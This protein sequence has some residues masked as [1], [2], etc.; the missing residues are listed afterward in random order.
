MKMEDIRLVQ[1]ETKNRIKQGKC[2]P[3]ILDNPEAEEI[4]QEMCTLF[5][6]LVVLTKQHSQK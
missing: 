5:D 6:K 1:E 3:S 2:A 4:F